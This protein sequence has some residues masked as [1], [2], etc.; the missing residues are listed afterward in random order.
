LAGLI[1]LADDFFSLAIPVYLH[2]KILSMFKKLF[3]IGLLLSSQ[4]VSAQKLDDI[5]DLMG[6]FKYREAKAAIEKYLENPKKTNDAEAWY[7]KGR[8]CNSLSKDSTISLK[9]K[10]EL[11][12]ESFKAFK[13]CQELDTK[14]MRMKLEDHVSYFDLYGEL[15]N[16]GII[17][18]NAKEFDVSY[19]SFSHAHEVK[20]YILSKSY[21]NEQLPLLSFDTSLVVNAAVAGMNAKR[22]DDAMVFY[23]KITDAGIVGPDYIDAYVQQAEHYYKNGNQQELA[24]I[25]AKGHKAYPDNDYWFDIQ[26]RPYADKEDTENL[27]KK[28]DELLINNPSSFYLSYMYGVE[29][30]KKLNTIDSLTAADNISYQRLFEVLKIAITNEKKGD[31]SAIVLL[32]S[33]YYRYAYQLQNTIKMIKSKKPEAIKL[34]NDLTAIYNKSMDDCLVYALKSMDEIE[35]LSSKNEMQK[36]N[37]KIMA[38]Y[39]KDIYGSRNDKLKADQIAKRAAKAAQW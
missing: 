22:F 3:A 26:L 35:A 17:G 19:L 23:K 12:H 20:D 18:Y 5:N 21:S 39:L 8:I 16:L 15:Y 7:Y 2:S 4:L 29:L 34:K 24:S 33:K 11:K 38:E 10:F 27:L 9:D 1:R 13:K 31:L 36:T 30:A 37:Y 32:S 25:V 28:Y 14:D 6:A